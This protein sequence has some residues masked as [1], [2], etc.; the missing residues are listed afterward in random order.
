MSA[1]CREL[2][3]YQVLLFPRFVVQ[4]SSGQLVS[5]LS[6]VSNS[7]F[8]RCKSCNVHDY[9]HHTNSEGIKWSGPAAKTS[10]SLKKFLNTLCPIAAKVVNIVSKLQRQETRIEVNPYTEAVCNWSFMARSPYTLISLSL[11]K[12]WSSPRISLVLAGS[13]AIGFGQTVSIRSCLV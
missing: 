7:S 6:K 12:P 9:K 1:H 10:L 2:S 13:Q 5:Y 8:W 11:F 3:S 4:F